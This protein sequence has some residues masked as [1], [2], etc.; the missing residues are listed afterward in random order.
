MK[1][2][3]TAFIGYQ[4]RRATAAML[5]D[6]NQRLE[7]LGITVTE[8]STLLLIEAN[9]GITQSEIGRVLAI[10]RANMTPMAATL[11][12]RGLILREAV[13]GRSQG[14]SLTAKGAELVAAANVAI[15]ENEDW[16]AHGLNKADRAKLVSLLNGIWDRGV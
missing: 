4:L 10:K 12:A 14:L 11:E 6:M 9:P 16:L 2:P 3:M 15:E 1:I 7:D 5:T 8:M 13:N